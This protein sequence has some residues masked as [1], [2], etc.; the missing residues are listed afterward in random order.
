[1]NQV[2]YIFVCIG[3]AA[4]VWLR[5]HAA[6]T[7][8][9]TEEESAARRAEMQDFYSSQLGGKTVIF[10]GSP[11]HHITPKRQN[12]SFALQTEVIDV[13]IASPTADLSVDF[14]DLDNRL[15]MTGWSVFPLVAFSARNFGVG[16]DAART[17]SRLGTV[18]KE[19][20]ENWKEAGGTL[21]LLNKSADDRTTSGWGLL[22]HQRD[23]QSEIANAAV[24]F[25]LANPCWWQNCER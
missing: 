16:F 22:H 25:I 8:M 5:P 20:L 24:T 2:G 12:I 3:A 14:S 15:E 4:S 17:D 11:S 1:M 18:V 21:L 10:K 9:A 23:D 7:N 19:Y 13:A 6:A